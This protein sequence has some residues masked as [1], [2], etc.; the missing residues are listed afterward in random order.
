MREEDFMFPW[1]AGGVTEEWSTHEA[2]RGA[3]VRLFSSERATAADFPAATKALGPLGEDEIATCWHEAGHALL[4][5]RLGAEVL[6]VTIEGDDEARA[7]E[8]KVRWV[9]FRARDRL[10]ASAQVCLG[11]PIAEMLYRGQSLKLGD[12][13]LLSSWVADW[14]EF[15]SCLAELERNPARRAALAEELAAEAHLQLTGAANEEQLARIADM[16]AAHGTL[17][18]TLFLDAL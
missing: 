17:D 3:F 10:L 11:G 6:E 12:P 15:E 5:H 14:R 13:S 1:Q 9:G 16:L 4:A 7:A 18:A 2:S 8:A